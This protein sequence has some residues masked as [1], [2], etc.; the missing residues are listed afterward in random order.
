MKTTNTED[1]A[2]KKRHFYGSYIRVNLEDE[3]DVVNTLDN[4]SSECEASE[5]RKVW[6][7]IPS[8]EHRAQ[9]LHHCATWEHVKSSAVSQELP[10]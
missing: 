6:K 7:V 2:K 9:I 10:R 8:A 4:S 3:E 5:L 1:L